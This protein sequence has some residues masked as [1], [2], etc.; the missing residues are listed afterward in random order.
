MER[1]WVSWKHGENGKHAFFGDV[2]MQLFNERNR[3]SFRHS[4]HHFSRG[5][6][7]H[8]IWTTGFS[9]SF[10]LKNVSRILQ[11]WEDKEPVPEPGG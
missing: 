11:P 4:I 10:N 3:F 1:V 5:L 9:L 6:K 8:N 7:N 2:E